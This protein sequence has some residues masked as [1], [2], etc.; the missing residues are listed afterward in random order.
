M[1]AISEKIKFVGQ[2][3]QAEGQDGWTIWYW[4]P[5]VSATGSSPVVYTDNE[6]NGAAST[7]VRKSNLGTGNT[8]A[9]DGGIGL[10]WSGMT[11]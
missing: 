11:G 10:V 7:I 5:K 4:P 1:S 9:P 3:V 6:S 8:G 2:L